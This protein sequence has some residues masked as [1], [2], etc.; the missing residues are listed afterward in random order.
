MSV[1]TN[2]RAFLAPMAFCA[3]ALIVYAGAFHGDF[4]YDD[5]LTILDN[6]HLVDWRTFIGH[7]DHMVRPI[8]YATFLV[9]RSLYGFEPGG[10]HALN[11]VLHVGST[12]LVYAILKRAVEEGSTIPFW[13]ALIFAIHPIATETVTYISGRASG[14][15]AFFYLLAF[16]LYV[17]AWE[18]PVTRRPLY[19]SAALGA[20]LLSIG[21]KETAVTL[22]IILLLWDVVVRR[23]KDA[24]LRSAMLA[25][26][27]F[28]IVLVLAAGWAWSHPRYSALTQFS[29]TIRPF[30]DNLFSEL[31]VTAYA[32]RLY[33]SPWNQ[34]FD[35]DLPEFHALSQWPLSLDLLMLTAMV[36]GAFVSWRRFPLVAFGLS[37][38]FVQLL[39]P[40]VI[41]RNDLLS[42][43]NLY[44]PSIGLVLTL[45]AIGS[46]MGQWLMT[47][48]QRPSLVR[49]ASISI[50]ACLGLVLCLFTIQRNDLYRDRLFLWSDAV[51]KSPNKAR[52]HNNLG[53]AL[54]L[55][56]DWDRAIEE[57]RTAARLDPDF[58]LAQKNL[59]DAYLHHVGRP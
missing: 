2:V 43:R 30:W 10:Y 6:P 58:I 7:L 54:A 55:H 27:P 14:L 31:H 8:L 35:H 1:K 23:V 46:C 40:T 20:W 47:A 25:H 34:N 24:S 16:F 56:G 33:F 41:P 57:F 19:I 38:F 51:R 28:W 36:V 32:V 26:V 15:M 22:P 29:L 49:F 53:Y 50:A 39:P 52:P 18:A 4:H 59:R 12:I 44:L 45:V 21:S 17:R 42:E 37:W 5:S 48:V 9:D 3:A 11:L 13:T